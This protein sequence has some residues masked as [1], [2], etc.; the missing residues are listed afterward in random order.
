MSRLLICLPLLLCCISMH[1]AEVWWE[2]EDAFE[3]NFDMRSFAAQQY[4]KRAEGLSGSD[5]L[6]TG[7]KIPG[8]GRYAR[9]QVNV[10]ADGSYQFWVRK[11]WKHGPFDYR[12]GNGKWRSCG[13]DIG[14]ADSYELAT[15]INANWVSLG[16]IKLKKGKQVFEIKLS[17]KTGTDQAACFDCF[18]LC[19]EAFQPNGKYRPGQR[20]GLAEDGWWAFEPAADTFNDAAVNMRFLNEQEAGQDGFLSTRDGDFYLASGKKERFWAINAGP[21]IVRLSTDQL[22]YLAARLARLGYNMVRIHGD[23]YDRKQGGL[24]TVDK[25]YFKQLCYFINALK[26][27]GIYTK[28]SIYFPLW[29]DV[30]SKDK[31]AGYNDI[32]N[33]KPF[34]IVYFNEDFQDVLKSWFK[35]LFTNKNPVTGEQLKDEAA[36]G[37]VELVNE[38]SMFFWTF[39][40]KNVPPAQWDLLEKRFG[41]WLKDEFGSISKAQKRWPSERYDR[42]QPDAERMQVE[43]IWNLTGQSIKQVS[44][45]RKQRLS[46]QLRFM[47]EL[48]R[49]FYA[50]M[51]KYLREDLGVQSL[52]SASNWHTADANLLGALERYTYMPG[53]VID[54]HG[55]FGPNWKHRQRNW[56][57][58]V[59]DKLLPKCALKIPQHIPT[60]FV[61]YKGYP[62]IIT[63]T[64]WTTINRFHADEGFLWSAYA[65]L[66]SFDGIFYFA[67]S[68]ASWASEARSLGVNSPGTM[69]QSPA[70]ALQYRRGDVQEGPV[71]IH[72]CLELDTLYDFEGAGSSEA[73]GIDDVRKADIAKAGQKIGKTVSNI[74]PLAC[75]VG[76]VQRSFTDSQ[77]DA[78]M[79]DL[80]SYI[81]REQKQ[82][83]S[84]TGELFWDYGIGLATVNTAN[85]QGLTGFLS[86]A[87]RR[88]FN[89]CSISSSNEYGSIMVISLDGKP[90]RRSQKVLVQAFTEQKMYGFNTKADGTITSFGQK[91]INIKKTEASIS[92]KRKFKSAFDCD[93]HGYRRNDLQFDGTTLV[94]PPDSMYVVLT[95]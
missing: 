31:L 93:E 72:Q 88:E 53:D 87:G 27:Q 7:G 41:E 69:G 90:I 63:E 62:H 60:T 78:R 56:T 82:I 49:D 77:K 21:G 15:H 68:G 80:S 64:A 94:L 8:A 37:I 24:Q 75:Y 11:F 30:N 4:G 32:K 51:K 25:P 26:K 54:K 84:A 6:N 83:R 18:Y 29:V 33:K 3:H 57:V 45:A 16:N 20:I 1:S 81:N 39:N 71:L 5:W 9:W 61:E 35:Q 10:P 95:R 14:L 19:Q 22:D 42:D 17:D 91:P 92:F 46:D 48:Q 28:M 76:R 50:D 79:S 34:G 12:F 13:R 85:S 23:I 70:Y 36:I 52:V 38:D 2:G 47:V 74:D 86:K 89:D 59:G 40:R 65:S 58:T 66:Q 67:L 73:Q 43:E 44:A 55:Y